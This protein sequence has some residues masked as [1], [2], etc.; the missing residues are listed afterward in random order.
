MSKIVGSWLLKHGGSHD[1]LYY[2]WCAMKQRCY[3]KNNKKY[4]IYGGKGIVMCEQWAEDFSVFRKW[5][6][7]NG[8]QKGLTIDRI[9]GN[10]NYCPENCRWVDYY[11]QNHNLI[12]NRN[13]TFAGKTMCL[14]EWAREL[15]V[16][17][18]TLHRRLDKGWS[19]QQAFTTPVDVNYRRNYRVKDC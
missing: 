9:D 8:Y 13:I 6:T 16:C 19:V 1:S 17:R 14:S 18:G 10:K 4:A 5:A 12:K 3:N 11:G 2:V 7:E 15:N